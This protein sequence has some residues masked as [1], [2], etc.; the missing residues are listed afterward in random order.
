VLELNKNPNIPKHGEFFKSGPQRS[1]R[2]VN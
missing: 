1:A 2:H